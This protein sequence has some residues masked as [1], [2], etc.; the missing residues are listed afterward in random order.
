MVQGFEDDP[1]ENA[2]TPGH[3]CCKAMVEILRLTIDECEHDLSQQRLRNLGLFVFASLEQESR[4]LPPFEELSGTGVFMG[5]LPQRIGFSDFTRTCL[6][7]YVK[8]SS[9]LLGIDADESTITLFTNYTVYY[10]V[11]TRKILSLLEDTKDQKEPFAEE[12]RRMR[13]SIEYT[14]RE[15]KTTPVHIKISDDETFTELVQKI[16][17]KIKMFISWMIH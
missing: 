11:K 10:W 8:Q 4:T 2:G 6:R 13:E 9:Q 12:I 7:E 3:E 14:R 1:T 16:I 15:F 5:D 17:K